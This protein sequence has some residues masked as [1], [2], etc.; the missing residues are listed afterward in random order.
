M[1]FPAIFSQFSGA[2]WTTRAR[3]MWDYFPARD[4]ARARTNEIV[5]ERLNAYPPGHIRRFAGAFLVAVIAA[6]VVISAVATAPA[7]R[8]TPLFPIS[9]RFP[10]A[11]CV[12]TAPTSHPISPGLPQRVAL[13]E[14]HEQRGDG[15]LIVNGKHQLQTLTG[16]RPS[17]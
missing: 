11:S 8:G 6:P 14:R 1:L 3:A 17:G 10:R 4:A 12:S 2:L 15:P 5:E 7:Q 16:P 9:R 13:L